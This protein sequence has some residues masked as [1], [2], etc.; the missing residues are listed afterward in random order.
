MIAN[1]TFKQTNRMSGIHDI[2]DKVF[3]V[4]FIKNE[5]QPNT[6]NHNPG[7]LR[8]INSDQVSTKVDHLVDKSLIWTD[9]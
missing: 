1:G 6:I 8:D 4:G 2:Q 7:T 5:I 3:N 9:T